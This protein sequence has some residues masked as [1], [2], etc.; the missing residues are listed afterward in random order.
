MAPQ[1]YAAAY[2]QIPPLQIPHT[3]DLPTLPQPGFKRPATPNE[4]VSY[5]HQ[6]VPHPQYRQQQVIAPPAP[7]PTSEAPIMDRL[8]WIVN[9]IQDPNKASRPIDRLDF[10]LHE[11]ILSMKFIEAPAAIQ[12]AETALTYILDNADDENLGSLVKDALPQVLQS[13][14]TIKDLVGTPKV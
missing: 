11:C 6:G 3:P 4:I 14:K 9:V 13:L 5:R 12:Q 10:E 7:P 8:E 2:Y 1:G